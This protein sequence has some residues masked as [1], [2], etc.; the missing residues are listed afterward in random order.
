MTNPGTGAVVGGATI[1]GN[2]IGALPVFINVMVGIYFTLMVVQKI[3]QMIKEYREDHRKET[4][5]DEPS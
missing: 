1:A 2:L 5:Q 3:Y 4:S